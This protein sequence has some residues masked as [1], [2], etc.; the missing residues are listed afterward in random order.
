M[1]LEKETLRYCS[2]YED[3]CEEAAESD[4]DTSDKAAENGNMD[5]L[6]W[7]SFEREDM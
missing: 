1:Q 2:G 4:E 3:T 6:Q 5:I 7:L